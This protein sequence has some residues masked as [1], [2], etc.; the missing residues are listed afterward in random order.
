MQECPVVLVHGIEVL[1][2][3]EE[4]RAVEGLKGRLNG[5]P[6]WQRAFLIGHDHKILRRFGASDYQMREGFGQG[7]PLRSRPM[8]ACPKNDLIGSRMR[9]DAMGQ[10]A[11]LVRLFPPATGR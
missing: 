9:N 6:A 5:L 10:W 3:P 7:H 11:T 4:T 8:S 1:D 2:Q